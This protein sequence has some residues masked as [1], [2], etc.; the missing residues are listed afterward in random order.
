MRSVRNFLARIRNS[1]LESAARLIC[2]LTDASSTDTKRLALD[3][4]APPA[5]RLHH[6]DQEEHEVHQSTLERRRLRWQRL[7]VNIVTTRRTKV[8]IDRQAGSSRTTGHVWNKYVHP[9]SEDGSWQA[10]PS[11]FEP[12]RLFTGD[13]FVFHS[14]FVGNY[15]HFLH[16]HLPL[17]AFIRSI[18][19]PGSRIVLQD[20]PFS[21]KFFQWFDPG[22]E[23]RVAWIGH[24]STIFVNGR[25][26]SLHANQFPLRNPFFVAH[27]KSWIDSRPQPDPL[28]QTIIYYSRSNSKDVRHSR[29]MDEECEQAAISRI[30]DAM[31]RYGRTERFVLFN[32]IENGE[33]MSFANQYRLFRSATALI[34]PHGSG[35]ANSM[36]MRGDAGDA[37]RPNVI[38]FLP[39]RKSA[40]VLVG[41]YSKTYYYLSG[42]LPWLQ[43]HH[44]PFTPDS[45]R[46]TTRIDLDDLDAALHAMWGGKES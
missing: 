17:I 36:W 30:K 45:T 39:G 29:I 41:G 5:A 37:A 11:D 28:P 22:F 23:T 10:P 46:H 42:G 13:F 32:G 27:L 6:A 19:H 21:R 24:G 26:T 7:E 44:I 31:I 2:Q 1:T 20:S 9:E 14:W 8:R 4:V 33:T 16:D 35:M 3:G 15:G 25:V 12:R 18:L 40:H 38:E 43:F 34:G